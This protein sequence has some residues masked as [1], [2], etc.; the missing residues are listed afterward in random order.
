MRCNFTA[1][2]TQFKPEW[3][4]VSLWKSVG[5][6]RTEAGV[7][8][9]ICAWNSSGGDLVLKMVGDFLY[10]MRGQRQLK[11]LNVKGD[12]SGSHEAALYPEDV[13]NVAGIAHLLRWNKI[14]PHY[15][16]LITLPTRD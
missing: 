9:V 7:L 8:P 15:D 10:S 6:A 3:P 14:L 11:V 2:K 12:Q 5:R 1:A 13:G 16:A 4:F